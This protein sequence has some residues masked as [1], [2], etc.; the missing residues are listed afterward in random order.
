MESFLQTD[1]KKIREAI[2]IFLIQDFEADFPQSQPKNPEFRNNPENF[3]LCA[4]I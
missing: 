2:R 3:H 4:Y 1:W